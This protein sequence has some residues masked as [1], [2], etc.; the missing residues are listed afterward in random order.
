MAISG[1]HRSAQRKGWRLLLLLMCVLFVFGIF[2]YSYDSE[3]EVLACKGF[4]L[5]PGVALAELGV[6]WG[7]AASASRTADAKP[8]RAPPP[9]ARAQVSLR[10]NMDDGIAGAGRRGGGGRAALDMLR[11]LRWVCL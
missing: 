11:A 5:H 7:E 3:L 2:S 9:P 6:A 4:P 1:S 10:E 8:P